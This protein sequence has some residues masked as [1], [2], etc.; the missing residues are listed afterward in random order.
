MAKDPAA[1]PVSNAMG[2]EVAARAAELD[3]ADNFVGRAKNVRAVSV[4]STIQMAEWVRMEGTPGVVAPA[5]ARVL[6][7]RWRRGAALRARAPPRAR[8]APRAPA[9]L[10]PGSPARRDPRLT[11]L[12]PLRPSPRSSRAPPLICSAHSLRFVVLIGVLAQLRHV[13]RCLWMTC[14]TG[15]TVVCA[16]ALQQ[17]GELWRYQPQCAQCR[18]IFS[19]RTTPWIQTSELSSSGRFRPL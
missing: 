11:Y 16:C 6:H 14:S 3:E 17:V 10:L 18:A 15:A 12:T 5:P 7:L 1:V 13:P 9:V 8:A 4:C 2:R 19:H